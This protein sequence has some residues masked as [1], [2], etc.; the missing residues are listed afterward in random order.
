DY[1]EHNAEV[2]PGDYMVVE[3]TDTGIGIAP[4]ILDRVFEP[5]FT[6]KERGKATGLGLSVVFGFMKQSRGHVSVSSAAGRGTTFRLY[7]PRDDEPLPTPTPAEQSP[8]AVVGGSET[9][10]LVEQNASLLRVV[11][12][13]L[14]DVG[15]RVLEAENADTALVVIRDVE[16]I[17]LL[18]TDVLVPGELDGCAL[19]K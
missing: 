8:A 4:D 13:Q 14:S 17:D 11:A 16:P 5:F 9:I 6:T 18:L 7:L 15:Y 10:L 3:V 19:S 2:R 12:R 1:A